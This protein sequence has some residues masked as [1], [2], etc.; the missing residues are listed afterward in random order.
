MRNQVEVECLY[1]QRR[2]YINFVKPS[3]VEHSVP[4]SLSFMLEGLIQL[5][6][7]VEIR[8]KEVCLHVHLTVPR[9]GCHDAE[10]RMSR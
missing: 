9:R 7:R 2:L 4:G 8:L 6:M 10:A 1:D 5:R 3:H